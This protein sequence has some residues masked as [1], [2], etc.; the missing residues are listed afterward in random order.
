MRISKA[1]LLVALAFLAPIL[2]EL[3]T[4][5]AW[6]DIHLSVLETVF[7]GAIIAAGLL[8]WAFLPE[9]GDETT[10][11]RDVSNSEL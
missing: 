4:V 11:D 3:R 9:D 10:S 5:L 6:A 7:V 8:L 1:G 2:V